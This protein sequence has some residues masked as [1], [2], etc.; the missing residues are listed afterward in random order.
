MEMQ[1]TRDVFYIKLHQT[2]FL[3][4]SIMDSFVFSASVAVAMLWLHYDLSEFLLC[5][6]QDFDSCCT[7]LPFYT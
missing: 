4:L 5:H 7:F 3:S 2:L 6:K 1:R